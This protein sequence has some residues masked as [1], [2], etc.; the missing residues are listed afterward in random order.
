M[1]LNQDI[2]LK[3]LCEKSDMNSFIYMKGQLSYVLDIQTDIYDFSLNIDLDAIFSNS[4]RS[5]KIRFFT[6]QKWIEGQK[7]PSS[8]GAIEYNLLTKEYT[9]RISFF[10]IMIEIYEDELPQLTV[11][12]PYNKKERRMLQA[13]LS[14]ISEKYNQAKMGNDCINMTVEECG[15]TPIALYTKHGNEYKNRTMVIVPV[16]SLAPTLCLKKFTKHNELDFKRLLKQK[17]IV[18]LYYYNLAIYSHIRQEYLNAIIYSSISIE[19][20]LNDL[21]IKSDLQEKFNIY[22]EDLINCNQVPGFFTT[23]KFLLN[24]RII[25]KALSTKIRK[26]YGI[27]KDKRNDIIHGKIQEIIIN[28]VEAK[29][30]LEELSNIYVQNEEGFTN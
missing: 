16:V 3:E 5:R 26:C 1:F 15:A 25:D 21:I 13:V 7:T 4:N 24:E 9:N 29:K 14:Y 18:W 28:G 23:T 2:S 8:K 27:L 20:Y 17:D 12:N 10:Q 19:A 22:N 6:C 11:D 30:A